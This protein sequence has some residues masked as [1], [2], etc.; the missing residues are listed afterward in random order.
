[1]T[2][3]LSSPTST[4]SNIVNYPFYNGSILSQTNIMQD[5]T[6]AQLIKTGD[7]SHLTMHLQPA[8][9]PWDV[10]ENGDR[11]I[12]K[13]RRVFETG[14]A[15]TIMTSARYFYRAV[16]ENELA[17]DGLVGYSND[18]VNSYYIN[19]PTLN[20]TNLPIQLPYTEVKDS[21]YH[22]K[23]IEYRTDTI[24]SNWF[25]VGDI[26]TLGFKCLGNDTT[27]FSIKI[28]K[29]GTT[30]F[31]YVP[32]PSPPMKDTGVYRQY[33]LIN[34]LGCNYRMCLIN[35]D[36][37]AYYS[38]KI[39]MEGLP[40]IDTMFKATAMYRNVIDLQG[41]LNKE[42]TANGITIQ[43]TPNPATDQVFVTPYLPLNL[44][45]KRGQIELRLV[46][47]QGAEISKLLTKYGETVTI[48]IDKLSTGVYFIRAVELTPEFVDPVAPRTEPLMIER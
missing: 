28:Q 19:L 33:T 25:P 44:N 10:P 31:T 37:T 48:P 11:K 42:L 24:F 1:M 23:Y 45:R 30:T 38:E 43:V 46:N 47:T 27:K 34:G 12:W 6:N 8:L 17:S 7:Q 13:T 18:S 41:V 36:T 16:A 35:R 32:L 5:V 3:P 40:C 14:D 9:G 20:D 2:Q 21:L 22:T 4:T 29:Q 15:P 39:F 26:A